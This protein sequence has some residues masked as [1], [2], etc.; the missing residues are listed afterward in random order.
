[1]HSG[2]FQGAPLTS[3]SIFLASVFRLDFFGP[4]STIVWIS[5]NYTNFSFSLGINNRFW[6]RG[7]P[8][9]NISRN[10]VAINS[11]HFVFVTCIIR[12]FL[13]LSLY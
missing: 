2:D 13:D 12:K 7:H 9:G 8:T 10:F 3:S 4:G 1:M 11:M 5:I 6:D